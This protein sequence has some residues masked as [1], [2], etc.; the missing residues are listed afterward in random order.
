MRDKLQ[1]VQ[2]GRALAALLVVAYH[3]SGTIFADPRFWGVTPFAGFFGFGHAGVFFFFVLS[4]FIIAAAHHRDLGQPKRLSN[5]AVRRVVRVYPAYWI[6]LLPIVVLYLAKPEISKPELT[7]H[8]VVFNSFLLIG[9]SDHASLAVAWTM[10]HEILFYALFGIA[11]FNQRLGIVVLA[12]WFA[13]CVAKIIFA[14]M[15]MREVYPLAPINLLFAFGLIAFVATRGK[16]TFPLSGALAIAGISAFLAAGLLEDYGG[17]MRDGW[18]LLMLY[19]VSSAMT[20]AGLVAFERKSPIIVPA[21]A[22]L[23]GDASYAIYLVHYPA[24]S[25]VARLWL[26]LG[27]RAVPVP[28]AFAALVMIC[29]LLGIA[30]HLIVEKPLINVLNDRW[31]LH[32]N[33]AR[34]NEL[35]TASS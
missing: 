6:V 23:L 3:A 28:I 11:I 18:P 19:G 10:F 1:T 24:L 14:P 32:Q 8:A 17:W 25:I 16:R 13:L 29:A 15:L 2:V 31:R 34:G 20:L 9:P 7:S 33:R 21:W 5:Y 26:K 22:L 4:G 30:F 27:G 35:A 12:T